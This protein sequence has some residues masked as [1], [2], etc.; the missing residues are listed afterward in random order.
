MKV[1][2]EIVVCK[3]CP[4]RAEMKDLYK[5]SWEPRFQDRYFCLAKDEEREIKLHDSLDAPDWCPLPDWVE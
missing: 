4:N 3:T 1:Y 5:P 2:T